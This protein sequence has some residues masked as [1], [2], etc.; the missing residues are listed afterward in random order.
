MRPSIELNMELDV[1]TIGEALKNIVPE[2]FEEM[3]RQS[4]L[5]ALSLD[6]E[7]ILKGSSQSQPVLVRAEDSRTGEDEGR[8]SDVLESAA[9]GSDGT[10]EKRTNTVY[11]ESNLEDRFKGIELGEENSTPEAGLLGSVHGV[12]KVDGESH[13]SLPASTELE[14]TESPVGGDDLPKLVPLPRGEVGKESSGGLSFQVQSGDLLR[15]LS[16]GERTW[17]LTDT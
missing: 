10:L 5:S 7:E 1:K 3:V 17:K 15:D 16:G 14:R 12:V 6:M 4:T 11:S 8:E 9:T 13:H 2:V